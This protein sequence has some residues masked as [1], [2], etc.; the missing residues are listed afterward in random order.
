MTQYLR[1]YKWLLLG[2]A[3]FGRSFAYLGVPPLFIGEAFLGWGL[4]RAPI[5]RSLPK[6]FSSPAFVLLF[7]FMVYSGALTA[8][9][10]ATF[11][12]IDTLRDGAIWGYGIFAIFMASYC[13]RDPKIIEQSLSSYGR[14]AIFYIFVAPIVALVGG[15]YYGRLPNIPGT[16]I[17]VI[18]QKASDVQVHLAGIMAFSYLGFRRFNVLQLSALILGVMAMGSFSRGGFLAFMVAIILLSVLKPRLKFIVSMFGILIVVLS[19]FSFVNVE[20]QLFGRTMSTAQLGRNALSIVG[21]YQDPFDLGGTR[22]WRIDWWNQIV[23]YT[24]HGDYFWTGKG[25]GINL[26]QDDGIIDLSGDTEPLRSPHNSHLTFLARGGVPLFFF[27]IVLQLAWAI[28]M[29]R[30]VFRARAR[31]DT[32]WEHVGI[33]LLTYWVAMIVNMG[34]DVY[35]EGPMGGI[36]FWTIWGYGLALMWL[37]RHRPQSLAASAPAG[38]TAPPSNLTPQPAE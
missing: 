4:F 27:W 12:V 15:I 33:F 34:F 30:T 18:T 1:F 37:Y 24:F 29:L 7:A 38:A 31:G 16:T 20:V 2:Y 35:L 13:L 17:A 11:T 36:W 23:N 14:F 32:Y 28:G 10:L 26:A 6:L 22:Q 25:F 5:G 19:L 9:G 21:L 8:T 3:L